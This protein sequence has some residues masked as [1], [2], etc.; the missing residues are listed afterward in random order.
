[1]K[2]SLHTNL[3]YAVLLM[4][5]AFMVVLN[6]LTP[7]AI[8]DLHM[9]KHF[10]TGND[11]TSISDIVESQYF[12]YFDHT[13]RIVSHFLLQLLCYLLMD[14]K[15]VLDIMNSVV[16]V[17][18]ILLM[19]AHANGTIRKPDALSLLFIVVSL[20]TFVEGFGQDFLWVSGSLNY[21]WTTVL[22]LLFLLP[23][24]RGKGNAYIMFPLGIM[25]GWSIENLAISGSV[26]LL[27]YIICYYRKNHEVQWWAIAGAV[28]FWIGALILIIAPG[29]YVRANNVGESISLIS[30]MQNVV[31]L[32][33]I[34]MNKDCLGVLCIIC[35]LMYVINHGYLKKQT[36][37]ALYGYLLLTVF[38]VYSLAG[39]SYYPERTRMSSVVFQTIVC[40]MLLPKTKD[41][42]MRNTAI[43][44]VIMLAVLLSSFRDALRSC[45]EV[46]DFYAYTDKEIER[47]KAEGRD[48]VEIVGYMGDSRFCLFGK[49]ALFSTDA[50]SWVNA[51]YAKYR[52]IKSLKA[53]EVKVIQY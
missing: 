7:Y 38:S 47:A 10:V 15:W 35:G 20:F 32:T 2:T 1:M 37:T 33:K 36:D 14:C 52:G 46:R 26:L 28:G 29:N 40:C 39:V 41:L 48:S 44:L 22:V 34:F 23:Y 9:F 4:V 53:S 8:D 31:V 49:T 50:E 43:P 12:H 13:G 24:R 19:Y 3:S 42:S 45:E 17:G 30:I 5:F 16:F 25:A 51:D 21:L 6:H 18:L 11:L 27:A